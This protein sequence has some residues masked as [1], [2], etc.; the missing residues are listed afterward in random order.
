MLFLC[1]LDL[2][3]AKSCSYRNANS[4]CHYP[5]TC[6]SDG[7]C[8]KRCYGCSY[9]SQCGTGEQCCS[10]QSFNGRCTKRCRC[11][12]SR[13][14][15]A[16]RRCCKG[17]CETSCSTAGLMSGLIVG[18]ILLIALIIAI[19]AFFCCKSAPCYRYCHRRELEHLEGRVIA[20]GQVPAQPMQTTAT[21]GYIT[22]VLLPTAVANNP[23]VPAG[24]NEPPPPAPPYTVAYSKSPSVAVTEPVVRL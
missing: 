11:S 6:C 4:G 8:R 23:T 15:G 12:S 22:Q 19:S 24:F 17:F 5:E 14:C 7:V 13:Q 18:S 10:Y 3:I 2:T 20:V 9:E 16:D 1:C 21:A